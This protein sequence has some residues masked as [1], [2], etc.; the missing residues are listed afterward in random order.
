M[1]G[2]STASPNWSPDGRKIAF[3]SDRDAVEETPFQVEIYTMEADGDDQTRL[4]FD[5][6]SDFVP[7][8]SP[9][10]RKITF[11]SFRN[12]TEENGFNSDIYTM[13]ADGSHLEQLT[14]DLA[15]DAGSDWQPLNNHHG[16]HGHDEHH[17]DDD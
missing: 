17:G 14:Q 1:T 11:S 16:H 4:T 6:L 9:D 15:F 2:R 3:D 8:W 12:A 5:D 7:A 10:G 13:R